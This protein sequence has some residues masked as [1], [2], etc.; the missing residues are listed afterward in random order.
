MMDRIISFTEKQFIRNPETSS[1]SLNAIFPEAT[2][3]AACRAADDISAKVLV[4]FTQ[5]GFTAKLLSKFRPGVPIIAFTPDEMIRSR[6]SLYWG[7]TPKI[8]KLPATTD[9]M[10]TEVER[11]L[12]EERIVKKGDSIVITSS[13]PL[14]LH[15]K[16]NFM[17]LH[18]VGE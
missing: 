6:V 9:E 17:K 4:A 13:S 5:S 1:Y 2:A 7:I 10:V 11:L 16:T 3:D 14:T 15:G 12:L 18:R 8:M